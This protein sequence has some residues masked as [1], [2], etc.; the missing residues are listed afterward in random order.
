LSLSVD[1]SPAPGLEIIYLAGSQGSQSLALGLALT[2]A[3]QLLLRDVPTTLTIT[4]LPYHQNLACIPRL[5][6][7]SYFRKAKC[8]VSDTPI[9]PAAGKLLP[10]FLNS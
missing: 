9:A 1:L 4:E 10:N 8:S 6:A 3:P 2:A 5:L 7:L